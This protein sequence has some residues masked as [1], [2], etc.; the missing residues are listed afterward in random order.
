MGCG[1][2]EEQLWS[3][4][5]RD[6]PELE[7]HLAVCPECRARAAELRAGIETVASVSEETP[8][9]LPEQIG[10]YRIK[11]LL[12][13]GGMGVVY[14]AEQQAPR[15]TVALKV[16]KYGSAPDDHQIRLFQRETEVL[17]RLTHPAIAAIYEAGQTEEGQHFFAME[18]AP[19]VPLGECVRRQQ[20]PL[21]RRLELF[22]KICQAV[23]YAHRHDV[24]LGG[25]E[26]LA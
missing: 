17:A 7:E 6:A 24:A 11:R 4:I 3:W 16:L 21:D 19:G 14:E 2:S 12:G 1:V 23:D 25:M 26:R 8:R 18:L 20:L 9:H 5:D 13:E 10:S 22:H 15:R